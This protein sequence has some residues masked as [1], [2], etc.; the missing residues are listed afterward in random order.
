MARSSGLRVKICCIMSSEE[1]DAALRCGADVLGLVGRMPSGPG[2]IPD[3]LIRAL[4]QRIPPPAES[5]LLTSERTVDGIFAHHARTGTT[6]IQI[7][8]SL[9]D[10]AFRE[11]RE[12]L[13]GIRLIQVIHVVDDRSVFEARS[14]AEHADALLLDSGRPDLPVK[15][16]GGT[17]RTH[18]WKISRSIRESVGVPVFLAGGLRPENVAEAVTSVNPFAVDVCSGVRTEGRL[19]ENKVRAFVNAARTA[20]GTAH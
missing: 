7:V 9:P 15:E 3:D 6:G 14:A 11:L 18:N 13:P 4:A 1:A 5:F 16:L 20:A 12:R 8:D 10:G 19:D 17:G 2:V